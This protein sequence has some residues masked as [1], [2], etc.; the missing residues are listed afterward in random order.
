MAK[1]KLVDRLEYHCWEEK[2]GLAEITACTNEEAASYSAMLANDQ[3]IPPD[4]EYYYQSDQE[5]ND[6]PVFYHCYS[7][8]SDAEKQEFIELL[9]LG[10]LEKIHRW[11]RFFGILVMI[12]LFGG[13]FVLILLSSLGCILR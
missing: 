5:G 2:L 3:P 1:A 9:Q 6:Y 4:V 13:F 10:R 7:A 11:V 12:S 8:L